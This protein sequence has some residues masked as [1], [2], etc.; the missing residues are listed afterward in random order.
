MLPGLGNIARQNAGATIA[1]GL[2]AFGQRTQL[3][4]KPAMSVLL[5]FDDGAV[6]LG[7]LMLGRIAPL[8]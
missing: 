7:P 2:G 6:Q 4:G 3:E 5:R 1:A 8:F